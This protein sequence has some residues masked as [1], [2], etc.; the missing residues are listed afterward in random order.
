MGKGDV[1]ISAAIVRN[2]AAGLQDLHLTEARACELAAELARLDAAVR[3]TTGILDFDS[4]PASFRR[5]L[6]AAAPAG[7]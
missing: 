3:Q 1:T 6:E 2:W 5:I 4:E 7:S